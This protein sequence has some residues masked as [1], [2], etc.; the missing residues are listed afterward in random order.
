MKTPRPNKRFRFIAGATAALTTLGLGS[1]YLIKHRPHTE[2]LKVDHQEEACFNNG[3]L[4]YKNLS[5]VIRLTAIDNLEKDYRGQTWGIA[6]GNANGNDWPDLYLNHHKESNTKGRFPTS[7]LVIDPGKSMSTKNFLTLGKGDQHSAIFHDFDGDNRD[8][9]LETIGGQSGKALPTNSRTFNQLHNTKTDT[10]GDYASALG[11]EQPGAR[12]RNVSLFFIDKKLFLAFLNQS[13]KDGKYGPNFMKRENHGRFQPAELHAST[14]RSG[15]CTKEHFDLEKYSSLS[16]GLISEDSTPDIALCQSNKMGSIKLLIR[17][18]EKLTGALYK[19][20]SGNKLK[21]CIPS[22]FPQIKKNA[23]VAESSKGFEIMTLSSQT[24]T[25]R[26]VKILPPSRK[27]ISKDMAIADMNNDGMPD[28]ISLKQ[29]HT[30]TGPSTLIELHLSSLRNCKPQS[31]SS[32]YEAKTMEF[33]YAPAP[34]NLAL[35]DFNNDGTLDII[36]GAGKTLPGP[37]RG[38]QYILLAGKS[39]GNW[40]KLDIRCPDGSNGIGTLASIRAKSF[41]S[42]QIKNSGVGHETQHDSRIHFGFGTSKPEHVTV[43]ANWPNGQKTILQNQAI[44]RILR[45]N[46]TGACTKAP[47]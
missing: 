13:R 30:G 32:C 19:S 27:Q 33:S 44:N 17:K 25:L 6:W 8:E 36:I 35:A 14:C 9:V 24:N 38:G 47:H 31:L 4:C 29:G 21:F 16:Y 34:R 12:G 11:V 46:G 37:Y 7:H 39:T 3:D 20:E 2:E 23:V 26:T 15:R 10:E 18:S 45:V 43:T 22:Y 28:I 1:A 42:T 5:N 40:L 41:S